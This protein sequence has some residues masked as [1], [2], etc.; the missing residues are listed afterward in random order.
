MKTLTP[1]L[2]YALFFF[3]VISCPRLFGQGFENKA[4]LVLSDV[5][6]DVENNEALFE[7]QSTH[8]ALAQ[9]Q[10]SRIE[11]TS[12]GL[13][14]A[15][16]VAQ[17]SA[18]NWNKSI[19]LSTDSNLVIVAQTHLG[20]ELN[21][22][23][24]ARHQL[25][26][27]QTKTLEPVDSIDIGPN[28]AAVAV[29]PA[30]EFIAT[31]IDSSGAEIAITSLQGNQ[32]GQ[33]FYFPTGVQTSIKIR[34]TDI[35]WHPSGQY[36]AITLEETGMV[37]F[38]KLSRLGT[39]PVVQ[40]NNNPLK[41]GKRP[42]AGRFSPDGKHYLIT[43]LGDPAKPG[44]LLAIRCDFRQGGKHGL[45]AYSPVGVN[46]SAF[47]VSPDGKKIVLLN[48]GD[49]PGTASLQLIERDPVSGK[50]KLLHT[51]NYDGLSPESVQFSDDSKSI[52]VLTFRVTGKE[53]SAI[54]FFKSENNLLVE[55][56]DTRIPV[57]KGAHAMII[58]DNN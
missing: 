11:F 40:M 21:E 16:Q 15:E 3:F 8:M 36:L 50:L 1:S 56:P 20:M 33:T 57:Q 52:A 46:P 12:D 6:I 51:L 39:R 55:I 43:D 58:L 7:E 9:D 41:I 17:N 19:G 54:D 18:L 23:P 28:P 10:L 32:F 48:K 24:I 29:H 42:T 35:E 49:E 25:I 31:V 22:A 5:D 30:G 2:T 47:A 44:R 26:A 38:Y 34:A 27:Y 13:K 53:E 45:T 37:A 4:F 14:Y